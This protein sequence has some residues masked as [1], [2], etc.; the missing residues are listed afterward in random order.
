[1]DYQEFIFPWNPKEGDGPVIRVQVA[2]GAEE[3][4][5]NWEIDI[6][7]ADI[8]VGDSTPAGA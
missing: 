6:P 4:N 8:W 1:M 2:E 3:I 7:M 5:G